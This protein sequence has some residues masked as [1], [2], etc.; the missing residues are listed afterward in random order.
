MD[1][2][3][4][5]PPVGLVAT[6][7]DGTLLGPDHTLGSRDAAALLALGRAGVVRV[8]ATG[9][10]LHAAERVLDRRFPIDYLAVSSGAGVLD[11]R[12][13]RIL[14]A[15]RF[16][17]RGA[18]RVAEVLARFGVDFMAHA[19]VPDDHR[20][21][22]V[23]AGAANPDFERSIGRYGEFATPWED[24]G[25]DGDATDHSEDGLG[26]PREACQFVAFLR[27]GETALFERLRAALPEFAVI[28]STSP[29]DG[30]SIWAEVRPRGVGKAEAVAWL[31]QRHHLDAERTAAVGNDYNDSELLGW[32][33]NA[34]VVG[35]AAPELRERFRVVSPNDAGGFSDAVEAVRRDGGGFAPAAVPAKGQ[36]GNLTDFRREG[37]KMPRDLMEERAARTERR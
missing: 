29:Q 23:R 18:R 30:R 22:F 2:T 14:H 33:G 31:A 34:F 15:H 13:G 11:W 37:A 6:D 4:P 8:V 20:I 5:V 28:R 36:P 24:G 32:S 16:E 26:G 35:N 19:P 3:A 25:E 7:L 10:S 12:S 1:V 17:A 21:R 27:P 9:R